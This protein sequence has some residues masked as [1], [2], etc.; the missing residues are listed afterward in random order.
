MSYTPAIPIYQPFKFQEGLCRAKE[1][2][3]AADLLE[4]EADAIA[5]SSLE[6]LAKMLE[7]PLGRIVIN[8]RLRR[9]LPIL[10]THPSVKHSSR[11]KALE[12]VLRRRRLIPPKTILSLYEEYYD[13]P[14][15]QTYVRERYSESQLFGMFNRNQLL[16]REPAEAFQEYLFDDL[17]LR[18]QDFMA[19]GG[20]SE[21][22]RL[23]TEVLALQLQQPATRWLQ[24]VTEKDL[25]TLFRLC[26]TTKERFKYFETWL[27]ILC[28]G[29]LPT[30]RSGLVSNGKARRLVDWGIEGHRLGDPFDAALRWREASPELLRLVQLYLYERVINDF[31]S[32][33]TDGDRFQFWKQYAEHCTGMKRFASE[34]AFALRIGELWF[35]EFVPTGACYI[36]DER[37]F[38]RIASN[39]RDLKHKNLC[40]QHAL[41]SPSSTGERVSIRPPLSHIGRGV[42]RAY[43]WQMQ[44]RDFILRYALR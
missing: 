14:S 42:G 37:N 30:T 33:D 25:D 24:A 31:F 26:S 27:R 9:F 5:L 22:S 20:L 4:A 40:V 39:Y 18:L 17:Q 19:Q 41:P 7:P 32:N 3:A 11:E 21:N 8:R 16:T 36:Y 35:V 38:N 43:T 2:L 10:A 23:A 15:L 44:F 13:R 6:E 34:N 12:L 29:K 28:G 1:R